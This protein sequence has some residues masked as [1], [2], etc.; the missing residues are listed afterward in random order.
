MLA[1]PVSIVLIWNK[2]GEDGDLPEHA[3][4]IVRLGKIPAIALNQHGDSRGTHSTPAV[5]RTAAEG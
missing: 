1:V 2:S 4:W 3:R 5:S